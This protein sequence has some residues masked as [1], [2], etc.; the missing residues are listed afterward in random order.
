MGRKK[1][2]N[3]PEEKLISDREK[4]MRF[5]W[6]HQKREQKRAL[7]RYYENKRNIS[8]TKQD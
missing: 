2:Y 1:I 6:K 7:K 8:N 4:R 3:T 5:Y